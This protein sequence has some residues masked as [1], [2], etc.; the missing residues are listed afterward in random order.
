[1]SHV[2]FLLFPVACGLSRIQIFSP[3]SLEELMSNTVGRILFS[4][5]CVFAMLL[6]AGCPNRTSI[7]DINRDPGH[8]AGREITIAGR[9][10]DS[11]GALSHGIFAVDDGSG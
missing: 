10:S 8:F 4:I 11:Y 5:A 2:E 1:M 7:A 9:A 3:K 6:L